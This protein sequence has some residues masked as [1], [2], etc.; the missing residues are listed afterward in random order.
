MN[1]NI[2]GL[3]RKESL[4]NNSR[5][6][7]G[8]VI[9]GAP[10]SWQVITLLC[11]AITICGAFVIWSTKF[12]HT[13]SING[14]LISDLGFY[15]L[16]TEN[17]GRVT[18]L[19]VKAGDIVNQD[20]LIGTLVP[21]FGSTAKSQLLSVEVQETAN[22]E[23]SEV[24]NAK[25]PK[26]SL[27]IENYV[28]K[29][30]IVLRAPIGGEVM[31]L[32][33]RDGQ[34]VERGQTLAILSPSN[35]KLV[36]E[37]LVPSRILNDITLGKSVRLKLKSLPS[38]DF[39]PISGKIVAISNLPERL[40]SPYGIGQPPNEPLYKVTI[41]LNEN[42]NSSQEKKMILK[43]GMLVD[44][45]IEIAEHGVYEWLFGSKSTLNTK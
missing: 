26:K 38:R 5:S 23:S 7:D 18:N 13:A 10:L 30:Q 33:I 28:D 29:K 22:I 11:V 42:I 1:H 41:E 15:R 21:T 6:L 12:T 32:P 9:L 8:D 44:G 17:G 25:I 27:P 2:T 3:F 36:V 39:A 34:I 19:R 20:D 31:S 14:T 45:Q 43:Q 37:A 24:K 4:Q 35:S 16:T 40:V